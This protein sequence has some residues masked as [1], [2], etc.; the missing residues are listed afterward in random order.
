MRYLLKL[1]DFLSDLMRDR[2]DEIVPETKVCAETLS[3]VF[4]RVV[5]VV[6]VPFEL[7][8]H[9]NASDPHVDLDDPYLL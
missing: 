7:V 1:E 2:Q 9:S 4:R 6:D 3:K 5:R 8:S